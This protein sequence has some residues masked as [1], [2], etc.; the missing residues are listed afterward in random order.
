M[1]LK[2][3]GAAINAGCAPYLDYRAATDEEKPVIRSFLESQRW[4][5]VNVE[6]TA[7]N[8]AISEIVPAHV[9]EVRQRTAKRV[10]KLP[11]PL[12]NV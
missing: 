2:E 3:G 5:T 8:Y 1:E 11:E 4:L 7:T 10:D 12:K 9:S 6:D